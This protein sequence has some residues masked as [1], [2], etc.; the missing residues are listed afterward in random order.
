MAKTKEP[1]EKLFV[2]YRTDTREAIK[3][4]AQCWQFAY[5]DRAEYSPH[6]EE[7][8]NPF[9]VEVVAYRGRIRRGYTGWDYA[10]PAENEG[11][12]FPHDLS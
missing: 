11:W 12:R 7:D 5:D 10:D 4:T 3:Y 6:Y 9:L 8:Y 1:T 2:A